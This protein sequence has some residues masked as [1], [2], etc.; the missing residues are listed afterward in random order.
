MVGWVCPITS[1]HMKKT[2]AGLKVY[3]RYSDLITILL[4]H[5]ILLLDYN[6]TVCDVMEICFIII[7]H[8]LIRPQFI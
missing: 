7:Q 4:I 5:N 2:E 6:T 1:H 3:P 8:I